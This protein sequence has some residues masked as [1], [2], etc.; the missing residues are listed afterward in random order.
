LP[1]I[2]GLDSFRSC[3]Q[4]KDISII[5]GIEITIISI[6]DLIKTKTAR[7]KDFDDIKNLKNINKEI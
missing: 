3:Y 2:D 4:K 6:D 5:D 1:V 7:Q